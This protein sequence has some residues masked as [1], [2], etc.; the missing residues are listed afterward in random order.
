MLAFA[1][2]AFAAPALAAGPPPNDNISN[3][4][5]ISHLP[6]HQVENITQATFDPSTDPTQCYDGQPQTVWYTFTPTAARQ[7]SLIP[8]SAA[9][10]WTS[11]STPGHPAR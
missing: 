2:A 4:T 9:M 3:A 6:F 10:T 1:P 8:P 7:S 11:A 5:V